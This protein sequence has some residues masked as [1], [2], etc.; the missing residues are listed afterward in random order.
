MSVISSIAQG[1]RSRGGY[2]IKDTVAKHHTD[3]FGTPVP[4][5]ERLG[6]HA[7]IRNAFLEVSKAALG[8]V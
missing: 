8:Y 1:N 3:S 6:E 5:Y 2:G 4:F 7:K